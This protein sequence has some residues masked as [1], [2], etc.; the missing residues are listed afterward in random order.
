MPTPRTTSD[1]VRGIIQT[2]DG[3][4]LTPFI[5]TANMLTT[6]VCGAS[7]Y[8]DDGPGSKMELIERWLS[9]HFYTIYDNQLS[10]AKAGSVAVGFMNKINYGLA[11]SM[12]G[13][14]AIRLDTD[15]NLAAID[16]AAVVT[17][18]I[19]VDIGWLGTPNRRWPWPCTD[20]PLE[21]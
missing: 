11:N 10:H 12:Y 9:A 7:G 8:S 1:L 14:Q 2:Q 4:D 3:V 20:V 15:G 16:N 21:G 6:D 19:K 13:Q 5:T 18:K 17:R